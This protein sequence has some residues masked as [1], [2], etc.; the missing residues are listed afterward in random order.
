MSGQG[1]AHA[2]GPANRGRRHH[3]TSAP[4]F[5]REA[6]TLPRTAV[7]VCHDEFGLTAGIEQLCRAIAAGGHLA[8]APYFYYDTGG[9]E[10]H[11]RS[12]ADA[13]R[14][15][16]RLTADELREDVTGAIRHALRCYDIP[17]RH[18]ALIGVGVA[19]TVA[20]RVAADTGARSLPQPDPDGDQS[21]DRAVE[22]LDRGLCGLRPVE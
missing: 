18:L 3:G 17:A 19:A 7:I 15:W 12:P 5:V 1:H 14:A 21:C 13:E 11:P 9:R 4:L 2:H 16:T 8:I 6:R 20:D 10:F 22:L